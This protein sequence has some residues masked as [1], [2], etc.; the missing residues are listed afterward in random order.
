MLTIKL[1]AYAPDIKQMIYLDKPIMC[2][3]ELTDGNFFG[4]FFRSNSKTVCLSGYKHVMLSLGNKDTSGN[5]IYLD[6]IA[7][8]TYLDKSGLEITE[9]GVWSFNEELL[10]FGFKIDNCIFPNMANI[11][12]V[13]VVGNIHQNPE[14]LT[15]N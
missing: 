10:V 11:L 14:L 4:I 13:N 12:R 9:R 6:D 1:R 5:D 3:T 15:I 2:F 8:I 7:N